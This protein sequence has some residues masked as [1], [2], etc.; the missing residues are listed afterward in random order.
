MS[1]APDAAPMTDTV[2]Q[3]EIE[4][5]LAQAGGGEAA[6]GAAQPVAASENDCLQRHDF[7]QLSLFTPSELRKLRMRH[8]EFINSLAARLSIRFGTEVTLQMSKLDTALFSSFVDGLANPTHL[9]VLKLEP[10]SGNCLLDI[11]LRLGLCLVGRELGGAGVWEDEPRELTKMEDALLSR[12]VENILSEWCGVWRDLLD[13]RPVLVGT[14]NNGRFL[15]TC[16]AGTTLLVLGIELQMGAVVEEIQLGLPYPTLQPLMLKLNAA[17]EAE[18][19]PAATL[20]ARPVRWNPLLN[21]MKLRVTAEWQGVE[22]T[23]RQLV[24][25][26][27]GDVIPIQAE[28]V[29]RMQICLEGTPKFLAIPGMEQDQWAVRI[30]EPI[31]S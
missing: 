15:Q 17:T 2:S 10:L 22:V 14:E 4:K 29:N 6:G 18:Q 13:L 11:P 21:E 16:P 25:M 24:H 8:E 20:A 12:V 31:K 7:P 30:A 28:L 23:A 5:L 27:P 3:S 26:K 1:T 19:K 9:T